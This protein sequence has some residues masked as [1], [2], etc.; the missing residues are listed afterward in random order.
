MM[1]SLMVATDLSGRSEKALHRA[2]AL[3]KRYACPWTVLYVVD[4]DQPSALVE[5]EVTQVRMM[6]EARLVELTEMG[7]TCPKLL[8]ERGDP[9]QKILAAAKNLNCE[10]LVMGAHRKSVLR[11]IFVGTTV[12]RVLRA[13]QLPVLVVNQPAGGQY[14]DLLIALDTSPASAHAVE[15]ANDLGLLEGAVRR[16]VYAFSPLAKGMMQYSGVSE[17][18]IDEFV[19]SESRQAVEELKTFLHDQHLEERIDEQLVAVGLPGNV[20]QRMV[21]K[22]RPDLLV[23]GTRGMGG[24]KRAL[25]G[26]V[27]DYALRELD[28]DILVVPPEA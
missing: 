8:V 6:L 21:D 11:D 2:A 13:G 19:S 18:R 9:N 12:E 3:A 15:V 26:S 17:E 4:E 22:H 20:L 10:M 14:R 7:G 5:Q 23:M 24:I 16:G 25:I 1:K 28:C 27:A